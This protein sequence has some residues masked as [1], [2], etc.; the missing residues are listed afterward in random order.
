MSRVQTLPEG[1]CQQT[2]KEW[3][4]A[5][6]DYVRD[7][8]FDRKQFV[9]DLDLVMGG[10]R[11]ELVTLELNIQGAE[12]K[13]LFWEEHGGRA[14][15]RN[16]VRKK[17][18][19]TQNSMKIAFRGKWGCGNVATLTR[20]CWPLANDCVVTRCSAAAVGGRMDCCHCKI[21]QT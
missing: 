2:I 12:R 18:Q 17:R 3:N 15:V 5:T 19:A 7:K 1:I 9:S 6:G 8:M 16:T 21:P 13:Q 10:H 20:T 4:D 14:T 11:Q